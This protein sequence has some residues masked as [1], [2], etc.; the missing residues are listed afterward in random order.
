MIKIKKLVLIYTVIEGKIR[1]N[2]KDK[3]VLFIGYMWDLKDDVNLRNIS[4]KELGKKRISIY[5]V[6]NVNW[7]SGALIDGVDLVVGGNFVD[8]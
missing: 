7:D 4:V 5:Y 3:I 8:Y 6:S 2:Y 1:H